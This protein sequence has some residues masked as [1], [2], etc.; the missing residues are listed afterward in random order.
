MTESVLKWFSISTVSSLVY[1]S[2]FWLKLPAGLEAARNPPRRC[3]S[4]EFWVT[5]LPLLL[6]ILCVFFNAKSALNV[7]MKCEHE[8]FPSCKCK[9]LTDDSSTLTHPRDIFE[10]LEL[11][12][13]SPGCSARYKFIQ[14]FW[15]IIIHFHHS[16]LR[17]C[18]KLHMLTDKWS[19]IRS[20][21]WN[22]ANLI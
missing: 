19:N 13:A 12:L 14:P 2:L 11:R 18:K 3:C 6:P 8:E 1:C 9:G 17:S 10:S 15:K 16:L 4:K 5:L 22:K 21:V 7:K 20:G